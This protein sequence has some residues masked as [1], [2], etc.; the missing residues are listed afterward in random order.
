MILV[1][2][3]VLLDIF[4]ADPTWLAWSKHALQS[5]ASGGLAINDMVF[6]ELSAAFP[7]PE[8][9]ILTLEK[10]RISLLRPS[11]KA[12]FGAGQALLAYKKNRGTAKL[13][14]P[15]FYIGAHAQAENLALLT[16][17]SDRYQ[18]YFPTVRLISP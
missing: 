15:D 18:T 6:A 11:P 3:C 4:T 2:T 13:I 7:S 9:E 17:D 8:A 5:H 12:L 14:L 16:R 1:D 10:M